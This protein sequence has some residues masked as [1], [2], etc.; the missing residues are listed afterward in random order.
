MV[1]GLVVSTWLNTAVPITWNQKRETEYPMKMKLVAIN[2]V[3]TI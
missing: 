3:V 1:Q 2:V